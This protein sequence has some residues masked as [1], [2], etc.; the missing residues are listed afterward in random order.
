LTPN[1]YIQAFMQILMEFIAF[2]IFLAAGL[3]SQSLK[4]GRGEETLG[5]KAAHSSTI[6]EP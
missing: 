4:E 6:G 2:G 3:T 5:T 1:I